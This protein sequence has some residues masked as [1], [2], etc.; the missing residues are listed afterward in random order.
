MIKT[1]SLIF[2]TNIGIIELENSHFKV[3]RRSILRTFLALYLLSIVM[4]FGV[5]V[6]TQL[7]LGPELAHRYPGGSMVAG[8][9][10]LMAVKA[11][12]KSKILGAI[13]GIVGWIFYLQVFPVL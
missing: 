13:F 10:C 12:V 11:G 8:L 9:I 1:Y 7:I 5:G 2:D 6:V 3:D 4:G